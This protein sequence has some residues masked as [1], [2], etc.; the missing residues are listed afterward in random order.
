MDLSKEQKYFTEFLLMNASASQYTLTPA[1][2]HRDQTFP[3]EI[4]TNHWENAHIYLIGTRPRVRFD[5]TSFKTNGYFVEGVFMESGPGSSR[6]RTFKA[7]TNRF[8]PSV[9]KFSR[10]TTESNTILCMDANDEIIHEIQDFYFTGTVLY[11]DDEPQFFPLKVEYIGQSFGSGNRNAID[12]LRSHETLQKILADVNAHE[13][14]LEVMIHIF[15]Y[16]PPRLMMSMDGH[17]NPKISGD[18]DRARAVDILSDSFPIE[19]NITI[20]EASLIR[21]FYPKYNKIFKDSFPSTNLKVLSQCY[22]YDFAGII[23]EIDTEDIYSSLYSDK[24]RPHF[25]H[26]A[27]FVL[28]NDTERRDFFI[29]GI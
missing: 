21:Y 2:V 4:L 28:H 17:G 1:Y 6:A 25:H 10:R 23:T 9:V 18:E 26:T 7:L 5:V 29:P 14:H 16:G 12:R 8:H 19:Q 27:Q 3:S 11:I 15:Y 24:V 20:I 13:P 22:K